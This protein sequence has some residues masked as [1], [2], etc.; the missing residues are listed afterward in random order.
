MRRRTTMQQDVL[1]RVACMTSW[2]RFE[3]AS[4]AACRGVEAGMEVGWRGGGGGG[5]AAYLHVNFVLHAQCE[6]I[7]CALGR[8][9][10]TIVR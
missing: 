10:Y 4:A 1:Q 5:G 6:R 2:R 9:G 3:A 8:H 7:H